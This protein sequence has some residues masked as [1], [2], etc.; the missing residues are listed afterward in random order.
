MFRDRRRLWTVGFLS[1]LGAWLTAECW[2]SWDS[3]PDTVPLTQLVVEYVPGEVALAVIAALVGWV[4]YHFGKRYWQRAR[5]K[6]LG[7]PS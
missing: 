6:K 2:A 3:S 7:P 4:P 5:R 1:L